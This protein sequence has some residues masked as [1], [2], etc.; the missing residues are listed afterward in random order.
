MSERILIRDRIITKINKVKLENGH[1]R[2]ENN[3]LLTIFFA[4]HILILIVIHTKG[5]KYGQGYS[6]SKHNPP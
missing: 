4:I 2:E 3:V 1:F 6:Q 5:A